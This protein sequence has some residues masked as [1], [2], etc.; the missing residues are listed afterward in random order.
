MVDIHCHILPGI[1]DGPKSWAVTAEMCRMAA[2]DGI[3]HI[4][5][6]PHGND[7]YPYDRD[8]YTEMLGQLH[9]AGEGK[10]TFSLG[11]DFHFSYENI[12]DALEHPR[13]YTI[14]DSQYLLIEFS[15]FGIPPS[16]K[17]NL[18][19]ISSCGMV[20]IITHP[21]RNRP[22]LNNPEMVLDFVEQG[23]LVQVT[24][25]SLTGYWGSRSKTMAEWLLK[26]QAVHVIASD[27]HDC[28]HRKPVLSEARKIVTKL[29]SAE[30]AEALFVQTPSAIVEGKGLPSWTAG[31][32][33]GA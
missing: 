30:V 4:V 19:S 25:N 18:L 31:D 33:L 29:A 2:L 5:A 10:L 17:Q 24:A 22:L 6:T 27:A 32:E 1:D 28:V 13:R 11:C 23:C 3:T 7:Q 20:P 15:D 26:R 14:G 12:Q 9:D 16:V 21:E 8:R